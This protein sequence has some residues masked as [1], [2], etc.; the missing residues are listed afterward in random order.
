E[1]WNTANHTVACSL[2]VGAAFDTVETAD[3][4]ET[5]V[6]N[7]YAIHRTY[8]FTLAEA[9]SSFKIVFDGTTSSALDVFHVSERVDVEF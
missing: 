9:H 6:E 8:T 3:V 1:N 7:D 2:L 5:V 4:T